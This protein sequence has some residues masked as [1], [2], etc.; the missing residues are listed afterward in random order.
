MWVQNVGTRVQM[1]PQYRASEDKI[2]SEEKETRKD[3]RLM[4]KISD[5]T[6][7]RRIRVAMEVEGLTQNQF[8]QKYLVANLPHDDMDVPLKLLEQSRD[9]VIEITLNDHMEMR[10]IFNLFW[11]IITQIKSGRLRS[12]DVLA[13]FEHIVSFKS[14]TPALSRAGSMS[15]I[16]EAPTR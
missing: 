11:V 3:D 10:N 9:L 15:D 8:I 6:I 7:K 4:I 16:A 5:E 12:K 13:I 14:I 2:M 1:F